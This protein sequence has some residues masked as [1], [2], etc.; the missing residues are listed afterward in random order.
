MT[1]RLERRVAAR[2]IG[3]SAHGIRAVR[4]RTGH[5]TTLV[6]VSA[7]GVGFETDAGVAPGTPVDV[8]VVS[9][10]H[11]RCRR[12]YVVHSRV[13]GLHPTRGVR[14]RVGVRLHFEQRREDSG[15]GE[16]VSSRVPMAAG[17]NS[18]RW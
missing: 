3:E 14:Y 9:A 13:C 17:G 10:E 4:L 7:D 18:R 5:Q 2:W 16:P 1:A 12:A 11:T 15:S 6:D 8:V